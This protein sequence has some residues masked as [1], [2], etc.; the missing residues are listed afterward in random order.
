MK[1]I[2]FV[3][4]EPRVLD[5]LRNLLR[6]HRKKWDMQFVVGGEAAMQ[7]LQEGPIDVIV[8]DMR[9][10]KVDGAR[11]LAVARELHPQAV[12]IILSGY[13]ELEAAMRA[14]PVAH[15]FLTK[16]CDAAMLENV[17]ERTSTLHALVSNEAVR[18]VAGQLQSLPAVPSLYTELVA[19]LSQP[20][21]TAPKVARLLEK[22][23]AMCA[24]LLQ[25]VN[26][27]YF[28]LARKITNVDEAVV[29]LGFQTIKS[30]TLS[31]KV[32]AGHASTVP[33]ISLEGLQ[34]RAM[35]AGTLAK[36]MLGGSPYQHEAFIAGMLHDIGTLLF[37][38]Q[39][40]KEL[41]LI[42]AA[43]EGGKGRLQAEAE[44]AGVTHA[45]LGG[46][47]LGIWGLPFPIVEAAL[48]HHRPQEVPQTGFDTLAAVYLADALSHEVTQ[49]SVPQA[50]E[51]EVDLP[52]LQ[53]LGVTKE[54]VD[55][56]RTLARSQAEE[57]GLATAAH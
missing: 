18:K 7:A 14:V 8:S 52:Y 42:L 48:H 10:P 25:L 40:P 29:Y 55:E 56:W 44:V 22:D 11:L 51:D 20:E 49:D 4:D 39:L 38:T 31:V 27:A 50:A 17:I 53:R 6:A 43:C 5:G 34:H 2:M 36:R 32:F 24:K 57:M 37:V 21:A 46:Y 3:D 1:R 23:M 19:M 30:L 26:S 41:T 9:M 54:K 15:Q 47:L 28:G 45:D 33:K 35:L 13:T 16:P 12:R